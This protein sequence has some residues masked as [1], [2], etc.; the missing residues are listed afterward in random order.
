MDSIF[1]KL[2]SS[3]RTTLETGPLG[4]FCRTD[5]VSPSRGY[6]TSSLSTSESFI[7]E[8]LRRRSK[9]LILSETRSII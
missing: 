7:D 9:K 1:D 2:L 4:V 5:L 3:L 8:I 6:R